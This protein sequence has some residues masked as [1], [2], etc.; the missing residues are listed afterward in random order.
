MTTILHPEEVYAS[1]DPH[2]LYSYSL[3]ETRRNLN[4]M[5]DAIRAFGL[6]SSV[7][8][9]ERC[10]QGHRG[11]RTPRMILVQTVEDLDLRAK[12]VASTACWLGH[13][14][15]AVYLALKPIELRAGRGEVILPTISCTSLAQV[16]HYAGFKPVFADVNPEDFTLDIR[17]FESRINE[18]TRAVM[19]IH[20]FRTFGGNG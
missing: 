8:A 11:R 18:R 19:P 17:S 2:P 3:A 5:L 20:I 1:P 6:G 16:T 12:S 15:T 13:G 7:L 4:Y 14:S 9:N 10:N